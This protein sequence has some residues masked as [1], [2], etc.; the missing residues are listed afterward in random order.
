MARKDFQQM[1]RIE[2]ANQAKNMI[3]DDLEI[4]R[5]ISIPI[6]AETRDS[7]SKSMA[8]MRKQIR[9]ENKA[10]FHSSILAFENLIGKIFDELD[11]E[12]KAIR[13]EDIEPLVAEFRALNEQLPYG[14]STATYNAGNRILKELNKRVALVNKITRSENINYL[15]NEQQARI[16]Y[17]T[18]ND[19]LIALELKAEIEKL[20]IG[21]RSFLFDML[22]TNIANRQLNDWIFQNISQFDMMLEST[23]PEQREVAE[24]IRENIK[25]IIN[26]YQIIQ[27]ILRLFNDTKWNKV[28]AINIKINPSTIKKAIRLKVSFEN[29]LSREDLILPIQN[30]LKDCLNIIDAVIKKQAEMDQITI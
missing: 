10:K 6:Q 4:V 9:A 26:Q 18:K 5:T 22:K 7:V 27:P 14:L 24:F 20:L 2:G 11:K 17:Y 23:D 29:C 1:K 15:K 3:P 13:Y 12:N 25:N 16:D 19:F 8:E 28:L 30:V 21:E